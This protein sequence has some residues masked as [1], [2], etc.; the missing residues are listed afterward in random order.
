MSQT[1]HNIFGQT[2]RE[3]QG[4][5]QLLILFILSYAHNFPFLFLF[6]QCLIMNSINKKKRKENKIVVPP[7]L[8]TMIITH[9]SY[10]WVI[11]LW[12]SNSQFQSLWLSPHHVCPKFLPLN[13]TLAL[14][15]RALNLACIC[16]PFIHP[17]IHN[18]T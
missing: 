12:F 1:C 17:H 3:I 9:A 13:S 7:Q 18:P 6:S 4:H 15:T 10:S 14:T 5:P 2:K 11:F 16:L 8:L